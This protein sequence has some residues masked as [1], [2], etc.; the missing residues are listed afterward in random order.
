MSPA[1]PP[2]PQVR[3]LRPDDPRLTTPRPDAAQDEGAKW[4]M[5][6]LLR[7]LER[8]AGDRPRIGKARKVAD[9]V[10]KMGQDPY[11]A[12]PDTDLSAVDL[13][14]TPPIVRSRFMGFYGPYG[15]LPLST[16]EEVLRWLESGD[17]AFVAFTDLFAD[18]F[19]QLYYR[20]WA[21]ARAITQFDHPA[22]D[23]FLTQL[24]ALSGMGTPPF[25]GRDCVDDVTR[26]ELAPLAIGRVKSAARLRQMLAIHLHSQ[27]RIEEFVETWLDFE[28]D[29][30]CKLGLQ[31]STLGR[32]F[33]IGTRLRSI[34]EKFRIH[35][36]FPDLA[37][38]RR[39]LPGAPGHTRLRDLIFSHIGRRFEVE[40]ALWLPRRAIPPAVMG[41]SAE[42]GWMAALRSTS[43]TKPFE[44]VKGCNYQLYWPGEQPA[45]AS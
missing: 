32:D 29:S 26:L 27:V 18:R 1:E 15:A 24:L 7:R 35:L 34:G 19:L 10:V 38:Y 14:Q 2:G 6:A 30:R 40:V 23:R 45:L 20:S 39:F 41:K 28:P 5:L 3:G 11:L 12:F 21:D 37:S 13:G 8:N 9:E 33:L 42:L 44:L 17:D 43:R 25:Q 31:G 36:E 16:T 4:G 22:D